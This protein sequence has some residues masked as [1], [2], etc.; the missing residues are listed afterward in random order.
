VHKTEFPYLTRTD[1]GLRL[2]SDLNRYHGK[3]TVVW[4]IP[5]G[6]VPVAVEIALTLACPLDIIVPRKIPIPSNTEAGYGAV[7]EDGVIVLNNLLVRELQLTHEE[8]ESHAQSVMAE[9]KRRKDVFRTILQPVSVAGK[10]ALVVDDGLASGY[11]MLAAIKSLRKRRAR[12]V[13]AA[14]P[15]ASAG[16]WN[17]VR[18][19]ADEVVCP[20]VSSSYPFAVAAFY[21]Q[22]FDLTDD[23]VIESLEGFKKLAGG[24]HDQRCPAMGKTG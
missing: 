18:H 7:T 23:D 24:C 6:G 9:I 21:K 11:T 14:V 19:E 8:I 13:V 22:W 4:A 3:D 5:R 12:K 16:A 2:A 1:A 15:V 20:I 17:L 10:Q